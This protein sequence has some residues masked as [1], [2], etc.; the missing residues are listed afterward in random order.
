MCLDQ[1]C[2]I[3]QSKLNSCGMAYCPPTGVDEDDLLNTIPE[4]Y[5][6]EIQHR[7]RAESAVRRSDYKKK[8][9]TTFSLVN[10]IRG[11]IGPGCFAMPMSFKQAGLWGAMCLDFLLGALSTVCMIKLVISAQYLVKL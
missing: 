8:I 11:M 3:K 10:M 5:D 4:K 1:L 2:V 9:S 6:D 7:K